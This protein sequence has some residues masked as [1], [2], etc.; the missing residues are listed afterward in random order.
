MR[1]PSALDLPWRSHLWRWQAASSRP[2]F[3]HTSAVDLKFLSPVLLCGTITSELQIHKLQQNHIITSVHGVRC[4]H[5]GVLRCDAK[6]GIGHPPHPRRSIHPDGVGRGKT[7][8]WGRMTAELHRRATAHVARLGGAAAILLALA[9]CAGLGNTIGEVLPVAAG[10][11][12]ANVPARSPDQP[13]YVAVHDMP[14]DRDAK[15][16]TV[17]ERKK[18]EADLVAVRD[19]QENRLGQAP[20]P[21][22]GSPQSKPAQAKTTAPKRP[23]P[24]ASPATSPQ[25]TAESANR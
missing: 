9:G 2:R 16:L 12:P 11:E 17:E 21:S 5:R 6:F 25:V 13:D 19:R 15:P 10:G 7:L 14:P 8:Y 24:P 4:W 3:R 18:L 22:P 1:G 20:K 23:K